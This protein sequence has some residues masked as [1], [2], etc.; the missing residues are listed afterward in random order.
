MFSDWLKV[1]QLINGRVGF[2]H[3]LPVLSIGLYCCLVDH[4]LG[5]RS[6][7]FLP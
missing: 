3:S 4:P 6:E 5:S 7:D 1:A 2:L